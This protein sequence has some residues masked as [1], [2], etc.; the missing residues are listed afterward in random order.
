M[1]LGSTP[2]KGLFDKPK[3]SRYAKFDKEEK[4]LNSGVDD[5]MVKLFPGRRRNS[6]SLK[7]PSGLG[8]KPENEFS[9]RSK[10][11]SFEALEIELGIVPL[12]LLD[13]R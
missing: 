5:S 11:V 1:E 8:I 10:P 3:T 13:E 9:P 4:K 12:S 7:L 6:R 2:F